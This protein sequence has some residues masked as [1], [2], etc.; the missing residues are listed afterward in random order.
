MAILVANL[1]HDY[2]ATIFC[3]HAHN[4]RGFGLQNALV[5]IYHGFNMIEGG[6]GEFGNRSGLPAIE[7]LSRIFKEK[8]IRL[9]TG[10]LNGDAAFKTARLAQKRN[11][12]FP[13]GPCSLPA[14]QRAYCRL[15]K[16]GRHQ[17]P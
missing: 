8:N 6:F 15:R 13:R 12:S 4:D 7:L 5:S 14:I 10:D 16:H 11:P 9:S 2:P 3:L 1:R 17:Y